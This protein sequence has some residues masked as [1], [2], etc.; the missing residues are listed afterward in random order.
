MHKHLVGERG[1]VSLITG[2]SDKIQFISH[3]DAI[4]KIAVVFV[5]QPLAPAMSF[6]QARGRC[7]SADECVASRF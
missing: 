6:F 7:R 5:F 2:Q 4:Q 1:K 3:E